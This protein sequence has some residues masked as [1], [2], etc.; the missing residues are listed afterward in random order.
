MAKRLH[1]MG[2]RKYRNGFNV[3]LH[4]EL[5]DEPLRWKKPRIIFVNSMSDLFHESVPF[6]FIEQVFDAMQKADTH[7]FQILTK[8]SRRL[9]ELRRKLTW[10]P[11]VWM[12]VTVEDNRCIKRIM[13][14]CST[15]A[16]VKWLSLEPMLGPIPGL[17]L[18]NIDWVVVGGESG[19]GARP[20]R[21]EWILEIRRQCQANDTPFFFKQWG[22]INKK[23]NGRLLEGRVW[24]QLPNAIRQH[25]GAFQLGLQI[26]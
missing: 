9:A 20:I 24:D 5:L 21:E 8:R 26:G 10:P 4:P 22:G 6:D 15:S 7:I 16:K 13:D 23:A 3:T 25:P 11:N 14:L 19:P 2:V 17:D 1:A 18:S 12:G